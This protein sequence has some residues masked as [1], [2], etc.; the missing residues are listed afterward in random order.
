MRTQQ[1][2]NLHPVKPAPIPKGLYQK[3]S[4]CGKEFGGYDFG[5][6]VYKRMYKGKIHYLC[7]YNHM[8]EFDRMTQKPKK[9]MRYE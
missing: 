5:N 4:V 7:G 3:C 6:Y 1:R 9:E 8:N 2:N